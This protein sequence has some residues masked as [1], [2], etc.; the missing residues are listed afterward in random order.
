MSRADELAE[1]IVRCYLALTRYQRRFGHR[2]SKSLNISGRQLSVLRYLSQNGPRS[3]SEISRFLYIRDGTTSPLLD[4]ME[5]SGYVR[6]H[7]CPDDNRKV[8]VAPT[9]LGRSILSHASMGAIARMRADLPGLPVAELESIDA[10]LRRLSDVACGDES[11]E[12]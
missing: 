11:L 3:V 6:R 10:A 7:R 8:L 4:R 5:Q 12:N 9:E 1:S 2:L